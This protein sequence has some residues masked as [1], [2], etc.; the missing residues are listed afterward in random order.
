MSTTKTKAPKAYTT[1]T[2]KLD[3][4][5]RAFNSGNRREY[6]PT[7]QGISAAFLEDAVSF[8]KMHTN[9]ST[10]CTVH[11]R[12]LQTEMLDKYPAAWMAWLFETIGNF[13]Y[14]D[15]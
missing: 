9:G 12:E 13:E 5:V 3:A 11:G 2:R 7:P 6:E 10:A 4:K 8:T 1:I 15:W 14:P